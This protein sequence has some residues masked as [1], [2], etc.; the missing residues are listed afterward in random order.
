VNLYNVLLFW[1]GLGLTC[2][3]YSLANS[4]IASNSNKHPEVSQVVHAISINNPPSLIATN[5][6]SQLSD[7]TVL[8]SVEALTTN[9][10]EVNFNLPPEASFNLSQWQYTL[11][12]KLSLIPYYP[13]QVSES[14]L[15]HLPICDGIPGLLISNKL[16]NTITIF[17]VGVR[18][19]LSF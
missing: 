8:K 4:S 11:N 6:R 5:N 12:S 15:N 13:F 2:T 9:N 3:A 14:S 10:S 17:S 18:F 1:I 7:E 16:G 19:A